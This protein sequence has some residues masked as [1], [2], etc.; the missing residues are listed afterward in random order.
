LLLFCDDSSKI[1]VQARLVP[2]NGADNTATSA[3]MTLSIH[4]K[5]T[6]APSDATSFIAAFNRAKAAAIAIPQCISSEL[7]TN[8]NMPGQFKYVEDW[9]AT[10]EWVMAVSLENLGLYY[11]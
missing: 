7:Y 1:P 11:C 6:V 8:P 3:L 9:N 10:I 5:V 2:V 4:V